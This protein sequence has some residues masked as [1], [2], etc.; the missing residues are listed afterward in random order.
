M[1]AYQLDLSKHGI[2]AVQPTERPQPTLQPGQVLVRHRAWSLNFRDLLIVNGLYPVST[3]VANLIPVSD[4]AGEVVEVG[5][6]VT[7]FA[8][9]DRVT[10]SFFQGWLDGPLTYPAMGT[11]L[12][13]GVDGL[14]AEYSALSQDGLVRIPEAMSFEA[15]ATLPCAGVTAWHALVESGQLRAG[16]TVLALGTGGVSILGLQIA[17]ARGAKVII[18]SSSDEKLARAKS[19]GADVTINYQRTPEWADA[20]LEATGGAGADHVIETGG[21]GTFNQSAKALAIH[22]QVDVIGVLTGLENK[23]DLTPILVKTARVQGIYVGSR[24][25]LERLV[26]EVAAKRIEPV[27]HASFPFDRALDAYRALAAAQHFGKIVIRA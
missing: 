11:A 13:G 23:L 16:Q 25:M 8:Q 4:A 1:R 17:K 19:L 20:V 24:A 2:D 6:G 26:Q 7:R 3:G 22:G 18:T 10:A 9:G 12:G 27:I 15:A 14:L 21:A 5:A